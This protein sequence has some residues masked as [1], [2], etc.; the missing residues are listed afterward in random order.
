MKRPASRLTHYLITA[1]ALIA[2]TQF[3]HAQ[4]VAP[5]IPDTTFALGWTEQA[6]LDR[7]Q[8]LRA[9]SAQMLGALHAL[10]RRPD[11][12]GLQQAQRHWTQ[13]YLA[14]RTVDGAGAAP[15]VIARTGRMID[16]RPARIRDVDQRIARSEGPDPNNVAVR[17]FGT[18]EY[19]L[20]GDG[21]ASTLP[22]LQQGAACEYAVTTARLIEADLDAL[23]V[24]WQQQL[25]RLGG[26]TDLPRRNLLAENIGLMLSG[27]DGALARLPKVKEA[28]LEAWPDWRSGLT[29]AAI[30]SQLA[31][32][33][34]AWSGNLDGRKRH[35]HSLAALMLEQGHE[36][37]VRQVDQALSSALSAA[38]RLPAAITTNEADAARQAFIAS[39]QA[40]KTRVETQV[41]GQLGILLGFN[42]NDGD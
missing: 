19:L 38:D 28:R 32:F 29:R 14:W 20:F 30:H 35:P 40:L 23:D 13:A 7:H 3:S 10:C 2:T 16:F 41:A 33:A 42:D 15:T 18:L 22:R 24:G 8:H 9:A 25:E 1:A 36:D 31:G 6:Y 11:A 4:T 34:D 37:S 5:P 21:Q 39:V 12:P 27:L 26:D 17:G